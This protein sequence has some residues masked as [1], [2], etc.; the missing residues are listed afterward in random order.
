M[1]DEPRQL[2]GTVTIKDGKVTLLKNVSEMNAAIIGN[3][4]PALV[5]QRLAEAGWR[6]YGNYE[7]KIYK[8]V[9]EPP[10][11]NLFHFPE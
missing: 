10:D 8:N 2:H 7:L 6:L 9:S 1:S 5:L 11:P 4:D 3:G